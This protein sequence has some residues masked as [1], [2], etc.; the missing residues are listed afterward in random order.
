MN[1]LTK[2]DEATK[3]VCIQVMETEVR[4]GGER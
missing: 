3:F 2:R 1:E 4:K